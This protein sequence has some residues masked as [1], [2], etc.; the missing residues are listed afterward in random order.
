MRKYKEIFK[1]KDMMENAGIPFTFKKLKTRYDWLY[2]LGERYHLCYPNDDFKK[3]NA[4]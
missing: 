3:G 1:L 4:A 2:N